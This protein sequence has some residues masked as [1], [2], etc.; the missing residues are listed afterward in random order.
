MS[1]KVGGANGSTASAVPLRFLNEAHTTRDSLDTTDTTDFERLLNDDVSDASSTDGSLPPVDRGRG[2][3]LCLLGC[4]LVEAMIWGLS[5]SFGIFQRYYAD[6]P[7]FKDSESIA[8]IGTLATGVSYL[9]MPF[10]SAIAIKWP[11]H[12]RKMCAMGWSLCIG[13]LAAA[14]LATGVDQLLMFQGLLYG[15]GWVVCYTPFLFILNEWWVA[16]RGFAYGLLFAASGVSGLIIPIVLDSILENYGF[17]SALRTYG[18]MIVIISGPGLFLIQH[19]HPP[20]HHEDQNEKAQTGI[21]EALKPFVANFHFPLLAAAVFVQ[22][23]GFFIPNIWVPDMAVVMGISSGGSSGLLALISLFQIFGQ[24]WQGWLSDRVNVYIPATISA[25]YC[26]VGTFFLWG[27]AKGIGWLIPFA[28]LWGFFSSSYSVLYTRMV[29]FLLNGNRL[30]LPT[31]E[32]VGMILYGFFSF[33]RGVANILEGPISSHLRAAAGKRMEWENFGLGRYHYI[34]WF[35]IAC[36]AL[37][38]LVG[39][40]WRRRDS[41]H[42]N[43][44][45]NR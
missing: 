10:T 21:I 37:S 13:A 44:Y 5:L 22:G 14:S 33:E 18:V 17:R 40:G 6:H 35:T 26:M 23:L 36:M 39:I 43:R 29:S 20:S 9:G 41:L 34:I 30:D 42:H 15:V 27:L 31:D 38:S 11:Q 24:I 16:R 7:L 28:M 25:F 12:R 1:S 8:T 3:W 19:R 2:A 32:R 4:W 45:T